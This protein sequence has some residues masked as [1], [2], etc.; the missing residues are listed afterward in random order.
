[1]TYAVR[2]DYIDRYGASELLQLTDRDG[3]GTEDTD[4]LN[5]ALADADAEIDSYAATRYLVPLSPVP[6]VIVRIALDITRYRLFA[7]QATEEVRNRYEDAVRFLK[8][9]ASGDVQLGATPPTSATT[10]ANA[11]AHE[12]EDRVFSKDSLSDY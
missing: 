10:P 11:P 7:N 6:T 2:Q 4:V 3:N 12:A 5:K 1:M 8:A 9:I